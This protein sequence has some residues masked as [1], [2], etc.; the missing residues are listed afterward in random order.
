M[1]IFHFYRKG[2]GVFPFFNVNHFKSFSFNL[3]QHCFCFGSL[4]LRHLKTTFMKDITSFLQ[5]RKV[6]FQVYKL[7]MVI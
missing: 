5:M 1:F 7:H 6:M 4:V 2:D 3:L